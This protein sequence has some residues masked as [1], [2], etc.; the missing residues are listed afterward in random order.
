MA[1]PGAGE[2]DSEASFLERLMNYRNR[3]FS[4]FVPLVLGVVGPSSEEN[5]AAAVAEEEEEGRREGRRERLVLINP[6]TQ[7]M[8]VIQ[9]GSSLEALIREISEAES[10]K[11]GPSPASKASIEAMPTVKIGDGDAECAICLDEMEEAREMPC[12]HRFHSN[13]IVKWLEMHGSCPCCR[14]AMPVEDEGKKSGGAPAAGNEGRR[15][16]IWVSLSV[17]ATATRSDSSAENTTPD[18]ISDDQ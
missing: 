1:A 8:I 4:I 14:Y 11:S 17:S 18:H 16:E 7:G 10:A 5:A 6:I 12:R 3:E 13:C 9:G 2:N 15:R